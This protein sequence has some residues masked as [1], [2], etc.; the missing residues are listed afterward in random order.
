[1][2]IRV[3]LRVYILLTSPRFCDDKLCYNQIQMDSD[4]ET[5]QDS[6]LI[7]EAE[8]PYVGKKENTTTHYD[9]NIPSKSKSSRKPIILVVI[10]IMLLIVGF[11]LFK[12]KSSIKKMVMGAPTP[13]PT[14]IQ[15]PQPTPTPQLLIR[16]DWS[17]EVLNGSGVTGL[18]KKIADQIKNLGYSVIK[19]GNAD[20]QN[21]AQTQILLKSDFKDK[22]DLVI[23]DIKDI[24]KVASY[25][26][27]LK[28]S[29]ASARI[30][31]GK[32][33]I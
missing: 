11:L 30:I 29:T 2:S 21:Y 1:M 13:T 3:L 12:N 8:I 14:P 33:S 24:I 32:D 23:S 18:A 27:E 16:S 4:T 17:F 31:I 19:T 28:D 6:V 15:T 7:E 20:K 10:L 5:K 22:A 9:L 26:G 25:A